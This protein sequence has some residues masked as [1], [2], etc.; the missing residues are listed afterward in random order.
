MKYATKFFTKRDF[1][2]LDE[3]VSSTVVKIT[4]NLS[5]ENPREDYKQIDLNKLKTLWFE[6]D[7][8]C[9]QL[10]LDEDDY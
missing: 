8:Y 7:L 2:S 5:R 9:S 1:K 4:R 10:M 6:I 3:L